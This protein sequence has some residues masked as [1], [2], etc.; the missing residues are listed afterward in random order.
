[1]KSYCRKPG[2]QKKKLP[3][4]TESFYMFSENKTVGNEHSAPAAYS[5][6]PG[7]F[8]ENPSNKRGRCPAITL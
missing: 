4:L 1:M 3:A 7:T 2:T 5:T 8:V 6:T